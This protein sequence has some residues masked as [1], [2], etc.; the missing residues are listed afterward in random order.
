MS[1]T[2]SFVAT[3]NFATDADGPAYAGIT[4]REAV[5]A[6]HAQA[7]GDWNTWDYEGHYGFLVVETETVVRCGD[8][9]AF[10]GAPAP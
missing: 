6:A 10:K 5:M 1:D 8:F 7:H 9:T 3:F 2:L 4:P